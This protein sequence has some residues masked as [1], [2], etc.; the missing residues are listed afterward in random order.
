[1]DEDNQFQRL[2]LTNRFWEG[3]IVIMTLCSHFATILMSMQSAPT[4]KAQWND[5]EV[6]SLLDCLEVNKS[7]GEGSGNFK[8]STFGKVATAL[9]CCCSLSFSWA[10]KDSQALQ[11]EMG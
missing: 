9:N 1:M 8:D 7:E 10:K 3:T 5:Q 4:P 6:L 11:N 2:E